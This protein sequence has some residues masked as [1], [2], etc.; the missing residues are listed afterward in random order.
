[1]TTVNQ[2]LFR[3]C[4]PYIPRKT[5]RKSPSLLYHAE[6]EQLL[7]TAYHDGRRIQ[8]THEQRLRHAATHEQQLGPATPHEHWLRHAAAHEQRLWYATTHEFR[9]GRKRNGSQQ[10]VGKRQ[11]ATPKQRLGQQQHASS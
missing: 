2:F 7:G 3:V 5:S 4:R 9:L 8:P 6:H 1:M 10:R 11:H